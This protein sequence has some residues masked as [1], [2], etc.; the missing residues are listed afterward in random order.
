MNG[1]GKGKEW[2]E[3]EMIITN[4]WGQKKKKEDINDGD[5]LI[6]NKNNRKRSKIK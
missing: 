3:E 4:S 6:K 5:M 1:R 2:E